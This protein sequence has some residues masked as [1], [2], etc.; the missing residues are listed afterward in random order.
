MPLFVLTLLLG[1]S[2]CIS[3]QTTKAPPTCDNY[4]NCQLAL[5]NELN[6]TN[7][8]PWYYPEEFRN[9]VEIFYQQKGATGLRTVCKAFRHFKGC[10]GNEYTPC[11]TASNFVTASVPILQAYQFLSTFNQMHYVCGGG[12]Q[13]YLDNDDCMSATW[14]GALGEQLNACRTSYEQK[15]DV[16]QDNACFLANT[17]TACFEQQFLQGCGQNSKDAQFWGC[18]YARV[19]VFTRFPQCDISCVLPYA[20]GII[21]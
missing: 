7:P 1:L 5:N 9:K 14:S 20:G 12:M 11:M 10:M 13:I 17:L 4:L 8:Q 21:G 6:L 19:E 16:A 15:S 18:E 3:A 2:G